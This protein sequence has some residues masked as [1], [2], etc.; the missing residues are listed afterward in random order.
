VRI[1]KAMMIFF[2]G[3]IEMI[4]VTAWTKTVTKTKVLASGVITIVN[5][6]IWYYVLEKIVNNLENIWVVLSYALG[7]AV[8]TM[9]STYYLGYTEN[10][11]KTKS[12]TKN[13]FLSNL[14]AIFS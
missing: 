11:K 9:I 2:V 5:I 1:K 13:S 3:I 7:C 4:I 8:G 6:L 12:K 14:E 10:R